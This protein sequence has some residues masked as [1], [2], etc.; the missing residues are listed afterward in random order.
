M[1]ANVSSYKDL[2]TLCFTVS[3]LHV[4]WTYHSNNSKLWIIT[5]N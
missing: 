3:L 4:A 5:C 2:V 1:N